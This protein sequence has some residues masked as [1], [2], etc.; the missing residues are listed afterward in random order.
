MNINNIENHISYRLVKGEIRTLRKNPWIRPFLRYIMEHPNAKEKEISR[1]LFCDNGNARA[2]A[3]KNIIFFFEQEGLIE[4]T[5]SFGNNL[6]NE[7]VKALDSSEIWQ[8]LKGAFQLTLWVPVENHPYV[9]DIQPV[10]DQWYDNGRNDLEEFPENYGKNIENVQLASNKVKLDVIGERYRP[11]FANTEYKASIKSNGE[12][13]IS[14]KST[15]KGLKPFEVKFKV[16]EV[17]KS[18]LID[19]NQEDF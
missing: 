7:G 2:N 8:G 16:N 6:T 17:V 9:L 10:P 19:D 3:V 1:D 11:T 14:A 4:S 18:A 15:V 12:V 5:P 13:S